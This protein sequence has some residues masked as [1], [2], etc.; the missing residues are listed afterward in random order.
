MV[1]I[2]IVL[3][4]IMI[5]QLTKYLI[6][7]KITLGQRKYFW[8]GKVFI[9]N[10]R[11]NGAAYGV[12]K[13]RPKL[14]ACLTAFSF[15]HI[16]RVFINLIIT[17]KNNKIYKFSYSF[18]L[19]G[20]LGNI[21]DRIKRKYVTDFVCIKFFKNAPIFNVADLFIVFGVLLAI[22][23]LLFTAVSDLFKTTKNY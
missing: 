21:Y 4:I 8:S 17:E 18:L 14:L 11:N 10:L 13:D 15:V 23:N 12:L 9:T 6:S 2:S 16:S 3:S 1:Y 19:G 7:K 22:I 5:D 20:A